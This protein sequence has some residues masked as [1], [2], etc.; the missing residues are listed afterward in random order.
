MT[1]G[2]SRHRLLSSMEEVEG[3]AMSHGETGESWIDSI[4]FQVDDFNFYFIFL[5][6]FTFYL[7][8]CSK[9][10]INFTVVISSSVLIVDVIIEIFV[11]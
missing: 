9:L 2:G 8:L 3:G 10:K 1:R 7:C 6:L 4:P 11:F 5:Q